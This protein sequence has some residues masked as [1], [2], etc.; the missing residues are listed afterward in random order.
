MC[1]STSDSVLVAEDHNNRVQE[2]SVLDGS[3]VRFIGEG[4]LDGP[5]YVDCN[6]DVVVVSELWKHRVSVISRLDGSVVEQFGG[7]QLNFPR[8]LRLLAGGSEVV[9]VDSGNN[10]LC[11]FTLRGNLVETMGRRYQGL[12]YPCDAIECVNDDSFI[13]LSSYTHNVVELGPDGSKIEV[14]GKYGK[15]DGEIQ[16]PRAL[17]MLSGNTILVRDRCG[18]R[19]Q[20]FHCLQLR[21]EWVTVCV[22]LSRGS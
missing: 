13:V 7:D 14:L 18:K 20:M 9:V 17:A 21:R 19:I 11:T 15:K 10:R 2:V 1:K 16:N 4:V 12:V 3:W 22:K 8:V 6:A 5:Q